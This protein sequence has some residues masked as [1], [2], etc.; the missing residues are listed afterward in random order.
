ML[1]QLFTKLTA[2]VFLVFSLLYTPCVAAIATVRRE[3]GRKYAVLVILLQCSIA[4]VVAYIVYTI[5][6]LLVWYSVSAFTNVPP[7]FPGACSI[8]ICLSKRFASL[9]NS[10]RYIPVI[11]A[12]FKY[13]CLLRCFNWTFFH[14]NNPYI[15]KH[16]TKN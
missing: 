3:L 6:K 4:W 9:F 10:I 2:F 12:A 14:L 5:G 13:G 16:N 11:V 8:E 1:P 15:N 7:W